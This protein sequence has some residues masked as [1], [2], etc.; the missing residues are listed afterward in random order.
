MSSSRLN[1]GKSI[2]ARHAKH[3]CSLL[4]HLAVRNREPFVG[5]PAGQALGDRLHDLDTLQ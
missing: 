1:I 3:F 2:A 5:G 4:V